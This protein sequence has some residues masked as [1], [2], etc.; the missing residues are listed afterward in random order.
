M[1]R[2]TDQIHSRCVE[3]GECLLWQGGTTPAGMP[4]MHHGKQTKAM[5]RRVLFAAFY[6]E[7]PEGKLVTPMCGNKLCLARKHLRA[8]TPTESKAIAAR[9]GVY[10]S[11]KTLIKRMLALRAK[12]SIT[13]ETVGLIRD[14]N[15]ARDAHEKTG[16][17]LPYCYQIRDGVRRADLSSPFAG[18]GART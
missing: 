16:V 13:E 14:A 11:Q 1:S 17:S 9:K 2:L 4:T 18:L 12:S 3:E 5:V 15:T 8:M 7:V 10:K 6:G